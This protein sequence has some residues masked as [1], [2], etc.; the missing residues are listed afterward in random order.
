MEKDKH[1]LPDTE[2][3]FA[4]RVRRGAGE[5]EPGTIFGPDNEPL[6]R[7]DTETA[8]EIIP[9]RTAPGREIIPGR[10]T[11]ARDAETARGITPGRGN[12]RDTETARELTPNRGERRGSPGPGR[13]R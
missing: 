1:V 3:T 8:G 5:T 11:G 2:D 9:G 7:V 12:R 10:D 4:G 6:T 13:A